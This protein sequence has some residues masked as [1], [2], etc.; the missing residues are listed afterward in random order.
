MGEGQGEGSVEVLHLGIEALRAGRNASPLFFGL[1]FRGRLVVKLE[2]RCFP[3][4]LQI[5][6][7]GLKPDRNRCRC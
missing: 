6:T 2:K 7:A 1:E 4:L 5:Y 3:N